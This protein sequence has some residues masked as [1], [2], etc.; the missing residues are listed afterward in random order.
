MNWIKA[1]GASQFNPGWHEALGLRNLLIT[2][3]AVARAALL[4]KESRG[5]HTRADFPE[6]QKEWL[7]YNIVT[8]KG[9]GGKMK[10]SKIER[11][12]P[13]LELERIAKSSIESLEAE[14]ELEKKSSIK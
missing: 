2:S 3:E 12:V 11:T 8:S 6:E 1:K 10:L 13:D 9:E 5:A 7:N 4:R 14:I